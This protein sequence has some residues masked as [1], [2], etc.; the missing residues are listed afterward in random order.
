MPQ[1]EPVL[2]TFGFSHFCEK[3]RWSLDWYGIDYSEIGWPPGL[4]VVLAKR[5][6]AKAST[7][8]LVLDGVVWRLPNCSQVLLS[9]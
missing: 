8:P 5:C 1:R 2:V 7:L 9:S 3:A 6:G 4:H